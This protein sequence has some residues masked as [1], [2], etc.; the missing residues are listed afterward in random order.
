MST[1]FLWNPTT[2]QL[3]AWLRAVSTHPSSIVASRICLQPSKSVTVSKLQQ[4]T[5]LTAAIFKAINVRDSPAKAATRDDAQRSPQPVS[6]ALHHRSKD[7]RRLDDRH[8]KSYIGTCPPSSEVRVILALVKC[9]SRSTCCGRDMWS[10][11]STPATS[12]C[13]VRTGR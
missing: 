1:T 11:V 4:R 7:K 12:L 5:P 13:T 3:W 10:G 6:L 8:I 2:Q 9:L